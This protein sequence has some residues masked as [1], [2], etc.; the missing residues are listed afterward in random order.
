[1]IRSQWSRRADRRAENGYSAVEIDSLTLEN[2]V[3]GLETGA[4]G[5]TGRIRGWKM[6]LLAWR[7]VLRLRRMNLPGRERLSKGRKMILHLPRGNLQGNEKR[8]LNAAS[9]NLKDNLC[10][11]KCSTR[12]VSS[13]TMQP[14]WDRG[15][16]QRRTC[17]CRATSG[18][19]PFFSITGHA[20][21]TR[22]GLFLL[23]CPDFI[24]F[25]EGP[26][27]V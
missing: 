4:A 16:L 1:M 6:N 2:E 14:V 22:P 11:W 3:P 24:L 25:L 10:W 23:P 20:T 15:V 26:S 21:G 19:N 12:R 13:H 17:G 7:V 8:W 9:T 27:R 18:V 5:L